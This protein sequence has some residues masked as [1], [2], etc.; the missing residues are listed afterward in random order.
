LVGVAV[1]SLANK[2]FFFAFCCDRHHHSHYSATMAL[3]WTRR[4]QQQHPFLLAHM[5]YARLRAPLEHPT[6]AEFRLALDP[7]NALAAATPGFVWSL[8]ED[9]VE[10]RTQVERLRQD[11][12]LMPQL[13]LWTD[14]K[15]LQ[16]FAFKSGHAMYLK[17]KREWFDAPRD[18]DVPFA[19]CWWRPAH[20]EPPTLHEAFEKCAHLKEHGPT[21]HAFTFQTAKDFP[22]P[23]GEPNS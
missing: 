15:S 3:R 20:Q 14:V 22:M 11:P 2:K 21:A 7:I 10:Q 13:S 4:L 17:R 8:N 6:M 9:A 1:G 5:N 19:V 18:E 23:A 16:H 12:F